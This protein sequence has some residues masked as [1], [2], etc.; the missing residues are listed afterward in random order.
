MMTADDMKLL[1]KLD[2]LIMS[3]SITVKDLMEQAL[4]AAEITDESDDRY[5]DAGPLEAMARALTNL[6]IQ[7]ATMTAQRAAGIGESNPYENIT[8]TAPNTSDYNQFSD[9][10]DQQWSGQGN[11]QKIL[12]TTSGTG[13]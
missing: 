6:Q 7:V 13:T 12:K 9:W 4:V 8:W 10:R 5:T 2:R 1:R 11:Y 3:D